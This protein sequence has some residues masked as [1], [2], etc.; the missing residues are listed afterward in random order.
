MNNRA[1]SLIGPASSRLA[2]THQ[3][4]VLNRSDFPHLCSEERNAAITALAE[5]IW[6]ACLYRNQAI[7]D[8]RLSFIAEAFYAELMASDA[9]PRGMGLRYLCIQE[10]RQAVRAAVLGEG[11]EELKTISVSS[12]YHVCCDYVKKITKR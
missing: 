9:P 5:I 7:E 1:L 6:A 8:A 12:L 2:I 10:I 11:D 4:A 3:E